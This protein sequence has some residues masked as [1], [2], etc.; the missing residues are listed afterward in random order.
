M[1]ENITGERYV[2]AITASESDRRARAAFQE[3]V[4]RIARPGATLYDFGAG[5]GI[6]ARF[7]AEHGFR[8]GAYDV[9]SEMCDCLAARCRDLIQTGSVILDRGGYPEFLACATANGGRRADLVTANFAPLS[10]VEDLR[11]LFAKFHA[12]TGADGAIL[13]SVLNPYFIGDLKYGWWW[14][15]VVRLWRTGSFSV[16]GAQGPIVRRRLA[17]FASQS[18]PYFTLSRVYRGLPQR[19]APAAHGIDVSRGRRGAWRQLTSS[20]FIFLL[21]RKRTEGH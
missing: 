17:E 7:Y 1:T 9:D 14:R 12:L 20:Q 21:F 8:V 10:L 2:T 5:P 15:N 4:V 16:A 6:D 3:L 11:G 18:A 13:A 19:R